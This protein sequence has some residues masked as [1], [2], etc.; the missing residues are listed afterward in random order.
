MP[1]IGQSQNI[2]IIDQTMYVRGLI[3]TVVAV[4]TG[5]VVITYTMVSHSANYHLSLTVVWLLSA[6]AYAGGGGARL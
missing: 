5:G 4:M 3:I 2:D 1:R 6:G